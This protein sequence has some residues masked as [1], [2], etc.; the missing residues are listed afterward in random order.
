M[1]VSELFET[2]HDAQKLV[3]DHLESRKE[4]HPTDVSIFKA[5]EK[6]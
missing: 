5:I 6:E 4:F 1:N 2:T 3:E